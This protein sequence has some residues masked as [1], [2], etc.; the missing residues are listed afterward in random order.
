ML[1]IDYFNLIGIY[2]FLN[3]NY[4]LILTLNFTHI[5]YLIHQFMQVYH[6][7]WYN[8]MMDHFFILVAN[9]IYQSERN[10]YRIPMIIVQTVIWK[11]IFNINLYYLNHLQRS[12]LFTFL[13]KYF[14][15]ILTKFYLRLPSWYGINWL[16]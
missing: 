1:M 13:W 10:Y 4:H 6:Y 9:L 8:F 11:I 3:Y 7:H 2:F 12:Q 16:L 14:I 5:N 15:Y